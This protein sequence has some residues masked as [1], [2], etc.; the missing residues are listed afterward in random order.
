MMQFAS[1]E[2]KKKR[3]ITLSFPLQPLWVK[4]I[5]LHFSHLAI[6]KLG[7][8][9]LNF[10]TI[11]PSSI[12][13]CWLL[14]Q[15]LQPTTTEYITFAREEFNWSGRSWRLQWWK[16]RVHSP[17]SPF[18]LPFFLIK[19]SNYKK[20]GKNIIIND[21]IAFNKV[22]FATFAFLWYKRTHLHSYTCL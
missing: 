14:T 6:S 9:V 22:E 7:L 8:W 19:K 15:M 5:H 11:L 17:L 21:H 18:I 1:Y 2:Y 16:Y 4:Y 10:L 20:D 3:S 12:A 13:A